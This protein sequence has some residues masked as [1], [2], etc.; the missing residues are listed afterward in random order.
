MTKNIT[1]AKKE[2][3]L[4]EVDDFFDLLLRIAYLKEQGLSTKSI[5]RR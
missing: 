2:I 3:T 5:K 1:E 4:K